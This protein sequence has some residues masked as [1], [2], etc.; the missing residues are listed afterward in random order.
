MAAAWVGRHIVL[1]AVPVGA[2]LMAAASTL[3]R[4]AGAASTGSNGRAAGEMAEGIATP[5][6]ATA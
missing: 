5:K 4:A 6:G 1:G 2:G 3:D